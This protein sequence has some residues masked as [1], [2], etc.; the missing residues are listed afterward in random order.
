MNTRRHFLKTGAALAAGFGGLQLL[1]G[2]A[3]ARAV[4]GYGALRADPKKILDLPKGFSYRVI[5]K[6]GTR[7]ADGLQVPGAADG[8]AAFPGEN[9]L[10]VLVRNHE[11]NP[12][13]TGSGGAF[14]ES[15]KKLTDKIREKMYDAGGRHKGKQVP[16][17]LGGTT[18]LVYDTKRVRARCGSFSASR[19]R[20]AIA[21]AGRRRGTAWITCEETADRAGGTLM[22]D[23]GYNFEV[24]A[25]TQP[26]LARAVPLKAMGRFRHEAVAVDPKTGI[27]YQTEDLGDSAIYRFI[28]KTPGKL[29]CGR[30]VAGVWWCAIHFR[31]TRETGR[32]N[33]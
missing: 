5:S 22:R 1:T 6:A 30:A 11:L 27:V 25:T 28:P 14:G 20:C 17:S 19:A 31:W 23:H 8:M 15:N 3:G 24:P 21:R 9:G 16:P 26:S 18:T 2:T 7:M 33:S 32:S 12:A 10:T 13:I 4:R 29:G